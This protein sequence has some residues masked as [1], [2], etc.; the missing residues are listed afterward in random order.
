MT[1]TIKALPLLP[2]SLALLASGASA[3]SWELVWSDEF[4]GTTLDLSSWEYQIGNGQSYGLPAG[5]GNNELQYYTNFANNV[6]VADGKLTITARQQNF[7]GA[8]YTSARIRTRGKRDFLYGRI[9]ASIKI[10]STPGVWPAFWMLP[11]NSP[12]GGWASSGE[13]DIMESVNYADRSYGTI[14]YGAGWPNN[15]HRGGTLADGRDFSDNFHVYAIEWEPDEIRWYVDDDNFL[16]LTSN[17]WFSDNA[18]GNAR[19]PFDTPFHILLNVAVGGNFPGDPNGASQFPQ[20]MEVDYVRVY[21]ANQVPYNGA[22][23][24]LPGMIQ[25]EDFDDGYNGQSYFDTDPGNNGNQYRSTDVDIEAT[26]GGGFNVGW[27]RENEWLEYTVDVPSAGTYE[28]TARVA[29]NANGGE[30]VF[31]NE[32]LETISSVMTVPGTGGWQNWTTISGTIE[33]EAG[34]QIIRYFHSGGAGSEFNLDW[35]NLE[36][37]QCNAADF[38]EPYGELDFFD[39]SAFLTALTNEEPS[40]DLS[41]D[42]NFDFFDVSAYLSIYSNGCP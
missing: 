27:M 30:F 6:N 34:E 11:T 39:L 9:E 16:T 19:A 12:Y 10:P 2:I 21:G 40:A 7:G 24:A 15:Q 4:D 22:P 31:Q 33:L 23:I 13:I 37:G 1:T 29:S 35:F 14:H 42:G 3:Q 25:A 17:Q 38:S 26:S 20:T 5:W 8:S 32:A 18:P 28:L 36:S 41:P